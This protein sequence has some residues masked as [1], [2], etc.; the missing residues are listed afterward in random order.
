MRVPELPHMR[1]LPAGLRDLTLQLPHL[2]ELPN[3]H[4]HWVFSQ[5]P[6]F[7]FSSRPV[8]GYSSRARRF[9]A[10]GFS[11]RRW[12]KSPRSGS[13]TGLDMSRSWSPV[14]TVQDR[15][16]L[17]L[18]SVLGVCHWQTAPEAAA[19]TRSHRLPILQKKRGRMSPS[20]GATSP[21][22]F[23]CGRG[24]RSASAP[25]PGAICCAACAPSAAL[26]SPAAPVKAVGLC[27]T[28]RSF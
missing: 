27:P 13:V 12:P 8:P 20:W 9:G 25:A 16:T 23:A 21:G 19:E 15:S 1:E 4:K 14:G 11:E 22:G 18:R 7:H 28:T 3:P 2:G 5:L 17:P 26:F 24:K 10:A 6:H